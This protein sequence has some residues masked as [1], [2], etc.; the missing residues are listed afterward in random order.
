MAGKRLRYMLDLAD[1]IV[2]STDELARVAERQLTIARPVTVIGDA[3]ETEI[4]TGHLGTLDAWLARR[5]LARLQRELSNQASEPRVNLVW[6]G[7]HGVPYAE[8]GLLDV[9]DR[10]RSRRRRADR[11]RSA[12]TRLTAGV[13]DT[14]LQNGIA[15]HL[16]SAIPFRNA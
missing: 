8:G 4:N 13:P 15:N 12:T 3:V 14:T 11:R 6:F 2:V 7:N 10:D 1:Q 16:D 9:D 5:R